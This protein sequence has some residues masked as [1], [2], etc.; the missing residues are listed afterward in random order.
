MDIV[1]NNHGGEGEEE[2]QS[3]SDTDKASSSRSRSSKKAF[4]NL[5]QLLLSTLKDVEQQT[6]GAINAANRLR[7]DLEAQEAILRHHEHYEAFQ[8]VLRAAVDQNSARIIRHCKEAEQGITLLHYISQTP[9]LR[10]GLFSSEEGLSILKRLAQFSCS[11]AVDIP[12]TSVLLNDLTMEVW[13]VQVLQI[14]G[15]LGFTQQVTPEETEVPEFRAAFCHMLLEPDFDFPDSLLEVL[16]SYDAE[17]T[18]VRRCRALVHHIQAELLRTSDLAKWLE[19]HAGEIEIPDA[20][21]DPILGHLMN[22]PVQLPSGSILD[23]AVILR[24]LLESQTDPFTREPL[25][26]E[27]L[28]ELPELRQEIDAWKQKMLQELEAEKQEKEGE[29]EEEKGQE[30]EEEEGKMETS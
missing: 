20:Y 1:D 30:E 2:G 7:Q 3:S 18:L 27:S 15:H 6:T 26:A 10:D 11:L 29:Q 21:L 8:A 16:E 9:E 24:H 28:R 14:L 4:R 23:R 25:R 5:R 17:D 22:D 13:R 12:E 19:Q